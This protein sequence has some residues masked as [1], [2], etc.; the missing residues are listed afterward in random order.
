M[1]DQVWSRFHQGLEQGSRKA[2]VIFPFLF[3]LTVKR[4]QLSRLWGGLP[5]HQTVCPL[6]LAWSNSFPVTVPCSI[7]SV[8]GLQRGVSRGLLFTAQAPE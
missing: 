1:T 5:W 2:V 4:D 7:T 6:G 8:K 3:E